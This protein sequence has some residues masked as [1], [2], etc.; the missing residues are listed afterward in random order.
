M[1]SEYLQI[2]PVKRQIQAANL[3]TSAG[4]F[5]DFSLAQILSEQPG[6]GF[7]WGL[8]LRYSRPDVDDD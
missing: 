1:V 8:R 2:N 5:C 6:A 7:H 4:S 3:S